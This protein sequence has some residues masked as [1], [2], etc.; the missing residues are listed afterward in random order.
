[1]TYDI[2]AGKKRFVK[3]HLSEEKPTICIGKNGISEGILKEITK[4]LDKNKMVKV[5]ILR[6]AL[7]NDE[8]KQIALDIASRTCSTLVE[9]KGHTLMLYKRKQK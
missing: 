9:V 7:Q 2:T 3:R 1:M 5:K 4:Q 6:A 8:A